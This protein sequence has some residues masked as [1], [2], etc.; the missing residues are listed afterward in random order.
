MS[1]A[2]TR[3]WLVLAALL[4]V[5]V[6]A[7]APKRQPTIADL[8]GR[9]VDVVPDAPTDADSSD[10]ARRNYQE[11]LNLERGDAALRA[12]AMRRLGDLKLEAG[13]LNRIEKELVQGSPLDT[14][15]AI[16]LYTKLL[17]AYPDYERNDAV[18]YQLA[19]AYEAD[20]Q[21]DKALAT[22]DQLVRRHPASRYIDEAQFRRG[23]IMFV[24]KRWADAEGAYARAI[25]FGPKSEFYEQSLYK[26]GW[27]L[28]KR[29][30]SESALDSFAKLLDI[31]L[32][33]PQGK[34]R[35]I[36]GFT[37]PQRELVED[38]LRV[39]A[40]TFSF[41][42]DAKGV[43]GFL[44]RHGSKPYSYLL[45]GTLGD[46][47]VSK[48]RWTDGANAYRA[49][50]KR[51]PDHERAPLLQMQAIDAYKRGGFA[52]LV[53]DGKREYVERYRLGSPFWA[54]RQPGDAPLV[55]RELK[56]NVKDL[57]AYYHSQAQ[58]TKQPADYQEAARW[59]REFL[60]SFPDDKEA[61][62]TNYLLADTLFESHQ[63]HDAAIEYEHTAYGYPPS[64]KSATAG[65][66]ALV[67]YDKQEAGLQG[68]ARSA[69]HRQG[70]ESSL[71]F[72]TT[73]Q[74]HPES[75][76]VLVRAARE[77][78][79]LKDYAKAIDVAD[80]VLAR[81][82]PVDVEKQRTVW[83]VI[84]NGQF[85][86]GQFDKA[87]GAYLQVQSLLAANDAQRPV[88]DERIAASVY[89]QGEARKAAGDDA[90]AVGDF[91]RV[92]QLAPH[93]KI[94]ATADYDAAAL[95]IGLK[96]WPKAIEVLE[97]FRR[98]FPASELQPEVTRKLAVA[99]VEAGRPGPAAVEFE[100]IATAPGGS[101]EVQR[102]ALAQAAALYEK[103]GD[104][105]K[106]IATL[107]SYVKRYP[108]PFDAA[109]EARQKLADL[110]KQR[111]DAPR[112]AV[113][114]EDIIKA[115]QGA[116]AT[117]TDR[118]RYLAAKAALELALPV[119]EAFNSV[120]LVLP[121]KKS[122]EAKRA[123]MQHA[124]K[125]LEAADAYA[126]AEVSTA[127]TFEMAELYHQLSADLLKSERPKSLK[128]E[129]LEQ[130]DLLLEEQS[131]PFEEKAIDI[132]LVNAAR[133]AQGL[134]D[135]SVR[136]S[137]AALAKLKPARFA[138]TEENEDLVI[139]AAAGGAAVAPPAPATAA[140]AAT[141]K[142]APAA[143]PAPPPG[144]VPLQVAVR[145]QEAVAAAER[146]GAAQADA[147]FVALQVAAPTLAGPPLNHGILLCRGQQWVEAEA[148][149]GEALKRNPSSA[150]AAAQLGVVYRQLGKFTVAEESYRRALALD[151]NDARTHRNLGVLLDLYVQK[152]AEA[153]SQYESALALA[154]GEDKQMSAWIA[155]I[156]Q[157]LGAGQKSARAE[158]Q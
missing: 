37:R 98:N 150:T 19:R 26:H 9:Q 70:L 156:R 148:A 137:F 56:A 89:K 81:Q 43:D 129:E 114:L 122:L 64:D 78:Y 22:L 130:Y 86:L 134:Y 142:A 67:S 153:L 1:R 109:L 94:R 91:L 106:T 92:A 97:G 25:A 10:R 24:D 3:L 158:A 4:A 111:G 71:R 76:P 6:A 96:D 38:T 62:A 113:L 36:E 104:A 154:G 151:A 32:L 77:F 147:E 13:E 27:A 132:H 107:E 57:A 50:A 63:F 149:L 152:P 47:Y 103:S 34:E 12:E 33:D 123:A 157:R 16:V 35:D 140:T 119:R 53:L 60:Q 30:E 8:K 42:D 139:D 79:D 49:F 125:A 93:A 99:Y 52:T 128:G 5:G 95:L 41:E 20:Q 69:W 115:D 58:A 138:K 116:G 7:G 18:L 145:F 28:F 102:E 23:E 87:E 88:I 101:A 21:G 40:I 144:G 39:C 133:A 29:G 75:A 108:Q 44:A 141:A 146:G 11:F 124:L 80:M 136:A 105:A 59:Y 54:H 73:F 121:L 90:G 120:R 126:I 65:Y 72:A 143:A 31:K 131:Y 155:E 117:R 135:E 51:E 74:T 85:E 14:A 83:T 118:S 68:E 2:P 66:A 17:A 112:R 100:R 61:A 127:A 110:A 55:V 48:E 82:P 84:A 15:D 46:L 45:Y